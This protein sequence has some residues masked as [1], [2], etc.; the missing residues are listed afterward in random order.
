MHHPSLV[1]R[2]LAPASQPRSTTLR[3]IQI[4]W[5]HCAHHHMFAVTVA[6]I[7]L[8]VQIQSVQN[9]LR[10]DVQ[11][12]QPADLGWYVAK[13]VSRGTSTLLTVTCAHCIRGSVSSVSCLAKPRIWSA[14]SFCVVVLSMS[15]ECAR[16]ST[17]VTTYRSKASVCA[18][19]T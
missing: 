2:R 6:V 9:V 19:Q 3:H 11:S 7:A 13:H 1:S 10:G 18:S 8:A 16:R 15:C 12:V 4:H 5:L 14:L 17:R